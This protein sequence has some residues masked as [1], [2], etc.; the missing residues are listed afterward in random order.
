[1]KSRVYRLQS[2]PLT[3]VFFLLFFTATYAQPSYPT[4]PD[5]AELHYT[6]LEHFTEAYHALQSANDT[7]EV[8][9]TMYFD[10]ATPG[11]REFI[12]KHQLTPE[13]LKD[14]IEAHPE[15]YALIP[16]LLENIEE[17]QRTH[18]ALMK[19]YATVLPGAMYA[20]TWLLVGA[21]R[22]IGQASRVGQLITVTRVT[23]D[24]NK[25]EKL[26]THELS[27]FQQAMAMGPQKY[28]ALYSTPNN[29]L[30]LCLREGG[31]EFITSLVLSDITQTKSLAFL[32][33][34]E[35]DLK[36]KFKADLNSQDM[37]YWMWNSL[38]QQDH[39]PLL[40]YV[41]GYKICA[42]YYDAAENKKDAL[43]AILKMENA[44]DFLIRSAYLE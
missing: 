42:A 3:C 26:M 17:L 39:P 16:G 4:D 33:Q 6:D 37:N 40:G 21:N 38:D 34:N 44:E 9:Q 30:G 36:T 7:L 31:A 20:P 2:A 5:L 1:M 32:E 24:L 29:M 28:G 22:G 18:K 11:L 15:R 19:K 43:K 10:R 12:S 8:L 25:L 13:L 23:D 14:A 27:H 41:M 35:K